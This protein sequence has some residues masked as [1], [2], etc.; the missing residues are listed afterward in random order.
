[1][2][3]ERKNWISQ[4]NCHGN[5]WTDTQ[6]IWCYTEF[7]RDKTKKKC[8]NFHSFLLFGYPFALGSFANGKHWNR[9]KKSE[10]KRKKSQETIAMIFWKVL[11]IEFNLRYFLM[12][13]ME[14]F[15]WQ[16]DNCVKST[17]VQAPFIEWQKTHFNTNDSD[18]LLF[19]LLKK[20]EI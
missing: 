17:F 5:R 3:T 13:E 1:M 10:K 11:H 20:N 15:V 9:G 16:C 18:E 2:K 8:E 6:H 7:M 19:H 12:A 4:Y 14:Y